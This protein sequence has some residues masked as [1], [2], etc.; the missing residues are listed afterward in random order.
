MCGAILRSLVVQ[1]IRQNPDIGLYI[2]VNYTNDGAAPSRVK[3]DI[4]IQDILK[5]VTCVRVVV[6][7]LDEYPDAVQTQILQKVIRLFSGVG[8]HSKVMFSSRD[9]PQISKLLGRKPTVSLSAKQRFIERDIGLFIKHHLIQLR[10]AWDN[11]TIDTI[12]QLM[13]TKAK[14]TQ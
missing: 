6:D 1:L 4:L 8:L 3:L 2:Y 9:L 5:L 12:G 14:G 11:S 13:T 7:G 10:G